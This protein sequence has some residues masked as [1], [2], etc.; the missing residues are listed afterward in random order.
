MIETIKKVYNNQ[1]SKHAYKKLIKKSILAGMFISIGAIFSIMVKPYGNLVQGLCF[2]IGL[3]GVLICEAK[4]FTGSILRVSNLWN[5]RDD[6]SSI[7]SDWVLIF[8]GNAIGVIFI[9]LLSIGLNLDN[10]VVMSISQTKANMQPLEL[11]IRSIFCNILVCFAVFSY[12]I[13]F[14]VKKDIL[15]AMASCVLPV[16]CFV[17]CGFEHSIAD[18]YY[19]R[20]GLFQGSTDIIHFWYVLNFSVFGNIIGGIIFTWFIYEDKKHI[21]F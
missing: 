1:C 10:N 14:D 4:L 3:V 6:L 5:D 12:R 13:T 18:L 2:S 11:F 9:S 17:A 16:A 7:I 15:H 21:T 8:I 19:M 20:I